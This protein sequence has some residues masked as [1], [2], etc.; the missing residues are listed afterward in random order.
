M[1]FVDIPL[2]GSL[3]VKVFSSIMARG[4]SLARLWLTLRALDDGTGHVVFFKKDMAVALGS[5]ESSLRGWLKR[6]EGRW[7]R[8]QKS[9]CGTV[10]LYLIGITKIC[11]QLGLCDPGGCAP[12]YSDQLIGPKAKAVSFAIAAQN[13]QNQAYHAAR[14]RK[15]GRLKQLV[16]RPDVA[17]SNFV[18][19]AQGYYV[20]RNGFEVPGA[21]LK[22]IAKAMGC[23]ERTA[24]RWLDN[25]ER[26]GRNCDPI[27]KKRVAKEVTDPEQ[28]MQILSQPKDTFW[29]IEDE[30]GLPKVVRFFHEDGSLFIL[31]TNIYEEAFKLLPIHRIRHRIKRYQ[32]NLDRQSLGSCLTPAVCPST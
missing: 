20:V 9:V 21:S 32:E 18:L 23:G 28:R 29:V 24:R 26:L 10:D 8:V 25:R 30:R 22:G 14:S 13:C 19:G 11:Y 7:W 6:G 12:V 2:D 15:K 4:K 16:L 27:K 31:G 3:V 5:S 17:A 1:R